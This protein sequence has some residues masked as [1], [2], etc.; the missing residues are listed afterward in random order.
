MLATVAAADSAKVQEKVQLFIY[1]EA[2]PHAMYAMYAI[3]KQTRT[4]CVLQYLKV[5]K[6]GLDYWDYYT[7]L[8]CLDH[9]CKYSMKY[10]K[11]V[12]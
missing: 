7:R 6:V 2:E 5:K 11:G 1:S 10:L 12:S 3:Y 9:A 4:L 8:S